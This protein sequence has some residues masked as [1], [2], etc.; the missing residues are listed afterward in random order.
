MERDIVKKR[1]IE[2]VEEYKNLTKK[3]KKEKSWITDEQIEE[4][5]TMA[6]ETEKRIEDMYE[7]MASSEKSEELAYRNKDF[8]K[9]AELFKDKY[10]AIKSTP[11]PKEEKKKAEAKEEEKK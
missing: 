3:L 5:N 6:E 11:K 1:A 8:L 2:Q 7:K 9:S 4:L 10:F